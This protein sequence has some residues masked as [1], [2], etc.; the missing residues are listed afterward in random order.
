MG[1]L[2]GVG[3]DESLPWNFTSQLLKSLALG[4]RNEERS[5]DTAQ[6]K[7]REDLH[8]VVEP[9]GG[10]GSGR[11]G[12]S[13]SCSERTK[14]D[15]CDDG[16]D[17]SGSGRDTVGGGTVAGGETFT[18]HNESG[19]VGA[20]VEEELGQDVEGQESMAGVSQEVLV[21]ESDDDEE[22]GE[23]G[24]THELDGLTAEGIDCCD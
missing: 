24:E 1:W 16:T 9:W 6:H 15:L 8:D 20:E 17:F 23:D 13:T 11:T 3:R 5:E 14:D 18:R 22:D 10:S 2:E 7:E 12:F 4:L 21:G 19:G